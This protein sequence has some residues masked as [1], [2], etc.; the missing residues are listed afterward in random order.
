MS[1]VTAIATYSGNG[2]AGS[3]PLK[4]LK[5]SPTLRGFVF[6]GTTAP[7]TIEIGIIDESGT[8]VVLTDGT[9]TSIPDD[10]RVLA[11]PDKGL[12]MKVTGG[13]PNFIITA[14]NA[15]PTTQ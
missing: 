13:S 14:L 4:E 7:T 5:Y 8:F 9:I 15:G 1:V 12:A 11:M 2:A 10:F 3:T 6:S